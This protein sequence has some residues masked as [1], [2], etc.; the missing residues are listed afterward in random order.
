MMKSISSTSSASFRMISSFKICRG[1]SFRM[2]AIMNE[3]YL[4]S[5]QVNFFYG[6]LTLVMRSVAE[7]PSFTNWK[8]VLNLYRKLWNKKSRYI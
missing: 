4:L 1:S 7:S 6:I 3:Q 8:Y 5:A 2:K